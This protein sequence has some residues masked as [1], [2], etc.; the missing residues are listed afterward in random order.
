MEY[1]PAISTILSPEYLA[2]F[3]IK[4]YGFNQSTTCRVLKTGINH[5]YLVAA[6]DKKFVP[7]VYFLHWRTES[8]IREELALLDYLKENGVS[9]SYPVKNRDDRYINCIS[10]LEGDRLA[11]LFSYAEGE[12]VKNPSENAVFQLGL[13]MAKIHRLTVNKT[14][15]RKSYDANSLVNWAL[16]LAR[17]HFTEP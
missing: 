12:L 16:Q 3:V 4:R 7:R 2:E 10:A 9:V 11:V 6:S 17:E 5:S 14:L 8:E 15:N 1:A 13:T